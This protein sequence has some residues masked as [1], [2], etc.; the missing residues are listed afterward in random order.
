[1]LFLIGIIIN[2]LSGKLCEGDILNELDE[3]G[4]AWVRDSIASELRNATSEKLE[5]ALSNAE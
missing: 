4:Y 2:I 1:M 3:S 5:I